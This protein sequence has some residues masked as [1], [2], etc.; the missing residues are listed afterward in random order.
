M[1]IRGPA[2]G[3]GDWIRSASTF[4][5][6]TDVTGS[7]GSGSATGDFQA[8][9]QSA[10]KEWRE[11]FEALTSV[12]SGAGG[13]LWGQGD[14][15][16]GEWATRLV[17]A[18]EQYQA[19]AKPYQD[20]MLEALRTLA[21]SWPEPFQPMMHVVVASVESGIEAERRMLDGVLA[22]AKRGQ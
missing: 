3:E 12:P 13:Q 11:A 16:A 4:G 21:S 17:Q 6:E 1:G 2:V 5:E 8:Q 7:T 15:G 10:M 19:Q 9:W 20:E 22:M 18:I 14:A